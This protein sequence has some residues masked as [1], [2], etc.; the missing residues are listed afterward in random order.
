MKHCILFSI[1]ALL[2]AFRVCQGGE[3]V[4]LHPQT[5]PE[6]WKD[7]DPDKGDFKEDV[8]RSETKDGVFSRDSYISAYVAGG[9]IRVY[10]KYAVKV[11]AMNAPGLLNVH[12]WM[13]TANI[14]Q[15][16]VNDGWA[17]MSFD[18]CGKVENRKDY[19][20]YP[21]SLSHGNMAGPV[22]HDSF[23]GGKSITDPRQSTEYLWYAIQSRALSYL[24]RQKEVD[25]NR[26]GAK[27]YSYGGYLMWNLGIDKRVKAIVAYFC[28]GWVEYYRNKGVWMYNNPY[29]EPPK[30][31]GEKIFLAGL[32][33]EAHCPYITAPTLWLNGSNDHAGGHERGCENFKMFKPGVPWDF[34]VQARAHHNT[35]KIGQDCRIWLEKYVLGRDHFWPAR[36]KSTIRLDGDGV[37]ELVVTPASP[38]RVRK[39]EFY[40]A[41]KNPCN[42]ARFWRDTAAPESRGVW[43]AK[44]PVLNVEDYVFGYANITYDN[45]VVVSTDFN[46]AIPAKLGPAKAT[47]TRTDAISVG[48]GVG[49]W[50]DAAPAEGIGGIKGFRATDNNKGTATDQFND[51]KWQPPVGAR[52]AF[53][54]FC[55][56]PQTLILT[57]ANYNEC[58]LEITASDNWQDMVIPADKLINRFNKQPMKSWTGVGGIR[59]MPK[60][61]SDMTKVIFSEVKWVTEKQ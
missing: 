18:Y 50:T 55:T 43:V 53:R 29:V 20:R 11:G 45:T 30:S 61:G 35:E 57:A 8:V 15:A 4:N 37:P 52:L 33:P 25:K 10:C 1:A 27:G 31:P 47:D 39:V 14:D 34:A 49:A 48:D 46:A 9:E 38:E 17:V 23:P 26:I 59:F 28:S 22:I 60:A 6:V 56:E 5:P 19:T 54:F 40:Y 3:G 51:P 58:E 2:F 21:G 13:Q 12:G 42:F 7:Y 32:A 16:Y 36:P 24:E 44:M 41:L